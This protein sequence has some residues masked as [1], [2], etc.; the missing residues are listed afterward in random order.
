MKILITGITGRIGA[1]VA[2]HFI[3]K[4]HTVRGFVWPKDRQSTKLKQLGAEIVEG[5]LANSADVTSA[6]VDQE[7]ILHLGAAFQAGGPFTPEQYFDTN[8]KGTFNILE[9][10]ISQGT[11]LKHLIISS[12]DAVIQKYPEEGI[13]AP[14]Q[15][16][17]LPL[18]STDWYSYSKILTEHLFDRYIR[19]EKLPGT[20][21]RYSLVFG[22]GEILNFPQFHLRT[23]IN[24]IERRSDPEAT[25]VLADMR[26]EYTGEPHLIVARDRRGRPWK[27]HGIDVREIVHAYDRAVENP[28]TFGKIYQLASIQPFTWDTLVPYLAEQIRAPYSTFDLPITPTYYEYD[29][30]SARRDFSYD[31]TL[32]VKQMVDDAVSFTRAKESGIIATQL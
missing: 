24:Q 31:P 7:I 32:T 15:T 25:A 23:F 13:S 18:D 19:H 29:L 16:D 30:S 9:A 21:F 20:I 2:R 22:A 5:D 10:A 3:D 17:T 12:T 8:I 27:K 11:S 26:A 28:S 4:G 6:A 1:N 14:L